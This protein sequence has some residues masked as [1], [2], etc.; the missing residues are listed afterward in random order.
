MQEFILEEFL[1]LAERGLGRQYANGI[2][3]KLISA[4]VSFAPP[5]CQHHTSRHAEFLFDA[6]Q[7]VAILHGKLLAAGG[8]TVKARLAQI[9]RRRL[10]EF[11]L[12]R[13]F[14]GL[15]WNREIRQ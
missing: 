2:I 6:R 4:I 8:K 14:L 3:R 15:T 9:L 5:D 10:H 12:L 13:S 7:R 1:A 11:R